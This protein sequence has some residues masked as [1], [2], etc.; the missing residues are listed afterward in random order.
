MELNMQGST[1]QG[2]HNHPHINLGEKELPAIKD[3]KVGQTYTV[4]LTVKEEGSH[5]RDDNTIH[6][7][8][9]V[10]NVKAIKRRKKYDQIISTD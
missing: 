8:F 6:A 9:C 1:I 3:W 2:E 5:L 4:E 10:L 7:E